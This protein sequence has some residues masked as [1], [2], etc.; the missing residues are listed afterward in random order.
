MG[1]KWW[2]SSLWTAHRSNS[3]GSN[4]KRVE[5]VERKPSAV[6]RRLPGAHVAAMED[7]EKVCALDVSRREALIEHRMIAGVWVTPALEGRQRRWDIARIERELSARE[8]VAEEFPRKANLNVADDR[9]HRLEP[10]VTNGIV[11]VHPG[12]SLVGLPYPTSIPVV[13]D[14][15]RKP[16]KIRKS[17]GN[18]GRT[19][20]RT[21]KDRGSI[22]PAHGRYK[23]GAKKVET[24]P[25]PTF[26]G[27]AVG[28]PRVVRSWN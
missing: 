12:E 27:V 28:V 20:T 26:I 17:I 15:D 6:P 16:L 24:P 10:I 4:T 11:R 21:Q 9:I 22:Q 19:S 14:N 5:P 25:Q 23:E 13:L 2:S 7:L 3:S 18:R 8:I 1:P